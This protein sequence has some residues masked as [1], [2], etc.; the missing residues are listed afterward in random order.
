MV[1]ALKYV[2]GHFVEIGVAG[3]LL[4]EDVR[5]FLLFFFVYHLYSAFTR[6]NHLR[7][8][9]RVYNVT[10]EAKIMAIAKK[11]GVTESDIAAVIDEQKHRIPT[12][13]WKS[14]EQDFLHIQ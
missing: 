4:Y 3:L 14:V 12:G 5:Y 9:V 8:M 6:Y 10:T 1:A 11:L 7:A 13:K 2:L